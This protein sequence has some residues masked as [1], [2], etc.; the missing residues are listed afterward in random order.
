M[1]RASHVFTIP[2]GADFLRSLAR[3]LLGKAG[4]G[5]PAAGAELS[6]VT[7]LLPTRRAGASFAQTL[8]EESGRGGLLLPAIVSLGG[9][10]D[11]EEAEAE[12][13]EGG[14]GESAALF[15]EDGGLPAAVSRLERQVQLT[16]LLQEASAAAGRA[17][18]HAAAAGMARELARFLDMTQS[19]GADLAGLDT[20]APGEMADHWQATLDILKIGRDSWPRYLM[21]KK[22]LDPAARRIAVIEDWARRIEAGAFAGPLIAA[23]S[24][25]SRPATARLLAAVA[26]CPQGAVV[27][28]GLDAG[29]DDAGWAAL[30]ESHPQYG[31]KQLLDKMGIPR[32]AVRRWPGVRVSA[33]CR[34]RGR[35]LSYAL[36]PGGGGAVRGLQAPLRD[37]TPI[38]AETPRE[39]GEIIA[40]ILRRALDR[41]ARRAALVTP[42]RALARRVAVELR[43]WGVRVDDSGGT[44]LARMAAFV[45]LRLAA[46]AAR[47]RLAPV[48]LL[49]LAKHPLCAAGM[50]RAAFLALLRDF[51][52]AV[53]R[54]GRPRPGLEGL[55]RATGRGTQ[56]ALLLDRLEEAFQPFLKLIE[57]GEAPF[58]DLVRTHIACAESL[59][60]DGQ[61][62]GR[63]LLWRARQGGA[64]ARGFFADVL[65]HAALLGTIQ[66]GDY[67][68]L[69]EALAEDSVVRDPPPF[70]QRIHIWGPLEARLQRPDLLVLGG[71][72]EGCWP[73]VPGGDPWL[74]RPMRAS[75]GL[76]PPE[77]QLGLAAHDFVQGAQA[78]QVWLTRARKGADGAPTITAR[79][80]MRLQAL[81]R[82][83]G[84]AAHE[85]KKPQMFRALAAALDRPARRHKPVPPAPRPPL[86]MRPRRISAT[87]IETLI[88]DPY[89]FYARHILKL[90]P[91]DALEED[92]SA[93]ERGRIIHAALEAFAKAFPAGLPGDA[94]AQ[95]E[96]IGRKV[97]DQAPHGAAVEAFWWPRF[98]IAAQSFIALERADLRAGA[99]AVHAEMQGAR[100]LDVKG[101]NFEITARA[102]RIDLLRNGRIAIYDYKTGALPSRSRISR[103]EHPQL[104]LEGWIAQ[105]GGFAGLGRR[106]VARL[107]HIQLRPGRDNPLEDIAAPDEE[108]GKAGAGLAKLL[109][110][111]CNPRQAYLSR[112][113]PG[114]AERGGEYDHLARRAEWSAP[115]RS[116][117]RR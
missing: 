82:T 9:L 114:A 111:Y 57:R 80:L 3:G 4:R 105:G 28:P 103:G 95:L 108:S 62:P 68:E 61:R 40:L 29:L 86:A 109:A 17:G 70:G 39:E 30:A 113:R 15:A 5:L 85:D 13:G 55:R 44:P 23:G 96:R 19:A 76:E 54:G 32:A 65:D 26:A 72:N 6:A 24:T 7:V 63:E 50:D 90:R 115:S 49:S 104:P 18:G 107:A 25:G 47:A 31:L 59:A 20:L 116:G 53:L 71:L 60:G 73:S 46:H 64:P 93:A 98:V 11:L 117:R 33:S 58:I 12:E 92:P 106:Q 35:L 84:T 67:P 88:H 74:S 78:P 51:E 45:F 66:T 56:F 102:D 81:R 101:Q 91:L 75:L 99:A 38:E 16:A 94:E 89:A 69:I 10:D 36:R 21:E 42:D 52:R 48:L 97:F 83:G 1:T 110:G 22:M 27:L 14:A 41:P 34:G 112:P 43:R 100:R 77:R 2:G 37:L 8:L 87:A 79:W